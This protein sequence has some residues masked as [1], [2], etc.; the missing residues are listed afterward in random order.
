MNKKTFAAAI[1]FPKS[2]F[3]RR[4]IQIDCTLPG[5]LLSED[6]RN[7]WLEK[8]Q[9]WERQQMENKQKNRSEAK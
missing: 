5:G 6:M 3:E 7:E 2:T 8:L 4:S 9:K 1:G